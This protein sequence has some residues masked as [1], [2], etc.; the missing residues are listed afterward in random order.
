[1]DVTFLATPNFHSRL[2]DGAGKR[3]CESPGK[4][5]SESHVHGVQPSRGQFAGLTA[6]QES[7][8]GY[9]GRNR[10][11]ETLHRGVRGFIYRFLIQT[12]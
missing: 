6:R 9:S 12:G 11:Q 8:S 1:M 5:L 10:P 3:K 4:A 2:L 7:N